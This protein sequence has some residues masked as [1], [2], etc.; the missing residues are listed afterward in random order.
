MNA[1]GFLTRAVIVL[2]VLVSA[3]CEN[4]V[5]NM[6]DQPKYKPLAASPLWA[7]GRA[8]RPSV[9]G[10]VAYSTGALAGTSSGRRSRTEPMA[11][12]Q[13]TYS[14]ATIERG[15]QRYEIYC[16]PCHGPAGD[17]NGYVTLRGFPHPPS[18]HSDRLREV[19]D[20][21][22]FSVITNGYGD[23]FPYRDR[24]SPSDRWAVIAY[25]R[26]LQLSQHASITDVPRE[27]RARL[28]ALP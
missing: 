19:T 23:M 4:G 6:Y 3:G 10:A 11:E 22:L 8:S 25:V 13:T 1:S 26:A 14:L 15:R 16:T 7:D 5:Q 9:P 12:P 17:G 28:E 24:L 27:E 20:A 21:Y 18:Y 2:T